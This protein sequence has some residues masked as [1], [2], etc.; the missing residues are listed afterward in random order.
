MV[1]WLAGLVG[2]FA[3]GLGEGQERVSD[4]APLALAA[5]VRWRVALLMVC[6]VL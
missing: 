1:V 2:V 6:R 3:Y 4:A 5:S